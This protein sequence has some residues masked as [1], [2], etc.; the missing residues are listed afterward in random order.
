[1]GGAT[2]CHLLGQ[3]LQ[4]LVEGGLIFRQA[5]CQPHILVEILCLHLD[6]GVYG[7]GSRDRSVRV[8][9]V[10]RIKNTGLD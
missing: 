9:S 5:E 3:R 7:S 1:M 2:W 10:L 4:T 8:V 6:K